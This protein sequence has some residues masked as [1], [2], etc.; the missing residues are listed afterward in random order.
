MPEEQKLFPLPPKINPYTQVFDIGVL[1]KKIEVSATRTEERLKSINQR[2][3]SFD[4]SID[5]LDKSL[6]K[7]IDSLEQRANGQET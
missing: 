6:N 4:Q 2:F 7:R 3:G 1:D 5:A